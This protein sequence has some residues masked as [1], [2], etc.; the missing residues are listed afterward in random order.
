M[1]VPVCSEENVVQ[2]AARES[3]DSA[4]ESSDSIIDSKWSTVIIY[5]LRTTFVRM[6]LTFT[7]VEKLTAHMRL[8]LIVVLASAIEK[9]FQ[10]HITGKRGSLPDSVPIPRFICECS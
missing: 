7:W 9:S 8:S 5:S 2:P 10:L 1:I 6:E 3:G 4:N